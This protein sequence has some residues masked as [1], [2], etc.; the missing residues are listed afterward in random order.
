[1]N[2]EILASGSKGNAYKISNRSTTLLIECGLPVNELKRKLNFK[3]SQI[4]GC[5]VTHEHMDH[6]HSVH[7]L[8]KKGIDVYM[9]EGTANALEVNP[10]F[11]ARVKYAKR[12]DIGDFWISPFR[13]IHD[14]LEPCGYMI[15]N[16]ENNESLVFITDTMYSPFKFN[17]F[18]Y[19]MIEC[20]YIKAVL[21]ENVKLGKIDVSLRNRIVR[22]HMSLETVLNLLKDNDT[23]KLK[24]IYVLHLSDSNSHAKE[25]KESIQ[26]VTGIPVE[27][28]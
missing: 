26:K 18:E 14:A 28:C 17:D 16:K 7:N 2:I 27:I 25:I 19:L 15:I 20:N 13:T 23:S 11:Y 9:T 4:D 1:M 6:A 10:A 12:Y 21:D 24:K 8:I 5:L 3:L 22:N